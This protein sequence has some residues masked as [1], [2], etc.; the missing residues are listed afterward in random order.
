MEPR[1]I[2]FQ[3]I[4]P[5]LQEEKL[6]DAIHSRNGEAPYHCTVCNCR[7]ASQ[8]NVNEH[9]KKD[10]HKIELKKNFIIKIGYTSFG[11]LV[12]YRL[13]YDFHFLTEHLSTEIHQLRRKV[14]Q[15]SPEEIVDKL[16]K[17][18]T[19]HGSKNYS[20]SRCR[21][22]LEGDPVTSLLHSFESNHWIL[23]MDDIFPKTQ[24]DVKPTRI[25]FKTLKPHFLHNKLPNGIETTIDQSFYLCTV[26]N[27]RI[28]HSIMINEHVNRVR[29]KMEIKKNFIIKIGKATFVCLSC[30]DTFSSLQLLEQHLNTGNHQVIRSK[31]RSPPADIVNELLKPITMH[32]VN[33]YSCSTCRNWIKGNQLVPLLHTLGSAH[34]SSVKSRLI[35]N[36][37]PQGNNNAGE[38][39]DP[40]SSQYGLV[41]KY[42]AEPSLIKYLPEGIE[43]LAKKSL[44]CTICPSW[45]SSGKSIDEHIATLDHRANGPRVVKA[46][47]NGSFQ[48]EVCTMEVSRGGVHR[49][50]LDVDHCSKK[51][52]KF[53]TDPEIV[54]TQKFDLPEGIVRVAGK[55]GFLCKFCETMICGT[56]TYVKRH[57]DSKHH[58]SKN[59]GKES[60]TLENLGT[61]VPDAVK[62]VLDRKTSL[63]SI[64][65]RKSRDAVKRKERPQRRVFPRVRDKQKVTCSF[66]K[67]NIK[68]I[69]MLHAHL[70]EHIWPRFIE[71]KA[72]EKLI[73]NI[74]FLEEDLEIEKTNNEPD[75]DD[76]ELI[77][78]PEVHQL[79]GP[80]KKWRKRQLDI[81]IRD[82]V[83]IYEVDEQ[84]REDLQLGLLLIIVTDEKSFH[85]L[86]C[87]NNVNYS[88]EA[89]Y[90]HLFQVYHL[91]SLQLMIEDHRMFQDYP[92]ELSDLALSYE[93]MEEV[94]DDSVE[95]HACKIFVVNDTS[96][97]HQHIKNTKH[98]NS[99]KVL[100]E[101]AKS[102]YSTLSPRMC[103]DYYSVKYYWCVVCTSIFTT[104]MHFRKHLHRKNHLKR[105]RKFTDNDVTLMF[106]YCLTCASLWFG[107]L[108]TFGYHSR[109]KM[110][111]QYRNQ[112]FYVV[113][114]LPLSAERLLHSPED[115]VNRL[116]ANID[117]IREETARKNRMLIDDLETF[118]KKKY[119]NC[120]AY[121]FGSRVTGLGGLR[122]DLDIFLDCSSGPHTYAR[123]SPSTLE[124]VERIKAISSCLETNCDIW[125]IN[126]VILD[127]RVPIVKL[128]HRPTAIE[129]DVSSSSSITVENT[130]LI[131]K[132]CEVFPNCRK[133]IIFMKNWMGNCDLTGSNGIN[134]YSIAW[135]VIF[136]LQQKGILPSVGELINKCGESRRIEGWEIGVDLDFKIKNDS[137]ASITELISEFFTFFGDFDYRND[138]IC[139]LLGRTIGKTDFSK[140]TQLPAE[141]A[142]YIEYLE[143]KDNP[144]PLRIDSILCIQDPFDLSH[145]VTKAVQ[146]C[147][148]YRLRKFCGFSV[149][150][151][152]SYSVVK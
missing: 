146:K 33:K 10:S 43:S 151:L 116:V 42:L 64:P 23:Q 88:I 37:V 24:L 50:L 67:K 13:F 123:R 46:I 82:D 98:T 135:M 72:D 80:R 149:Q 83:N 54:S 132:Y 71:K 62:P 74:S 91:D 6:P 65:D 45:L 118:C 93:Y 107:F 25:T 15:Q 19:I 106:D 90:E 55:A 144:E 120:I 39:K 16:L 79:L 59:A 101:K 114:S 143:S 27:C 9:V 142:P 3:W 102:W 52:A 152:D 115:K 140:R 124:A 8:M 100:N 58:R 92:D 129:C 89:L 84:K 99:W 60:R 28:K 77:G 26:C 108:H 44:F 75:Q 51:E 148:V 32:G 56:L 1:S 134:S 29:H 63:S 20:C 17:S 130:K 81:D 131:K 38:V 36:N 4:K 53:P 31:T 104:E 21:V 78:K 94:N 137:E 11:C 138:I 117:N 49:H 61:R 87:R 147:I 5:Y 41:S 110:H 57:V 85:C 40:S 105:A 125:M 133:M 35:S 73:R 111:K 34:N 139:P 136:F 112:Y 119:P 48:C 66:C 22:W 141:M 76:L 103:A 12:C 122:S 70:T 68:S 97:L 113:T 2:T 109:C 18:I 7:L 95:C 96:S 14:S 69:L 30:I 47:S 128:T 127:A 86:V 150:I 126:R 121:S 145:N